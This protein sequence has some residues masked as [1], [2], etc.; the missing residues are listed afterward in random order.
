MSSQSNERY[1]NFD[2]LRLLLAA[3]VAFVHAW[4][5]VDPD[6]HW[7]A[8]VMAV[9]AFL[10]ISGFLVLK[11]I[12]NSS[13]LLEFFGKRALRV[14]PALL[15][16]FALCV[17][18]F[19]APMAYNSLLNWLT[20]GLYTLPFRANGPLWSLLWEEIAYGSLALVWIAG[21][22][23]R[24]AVVWLMLVLAVCV[25]WLGPQHDP[26]LKILLY[27]PAAFLAG[28]LMYLHRASLLKVHWLI[29]TA[30]FYVMLQWRFVPDGRLLGGAALMLVQSFGVVWLGMAGP[31]ILPIRIPDISY[32]L[33]IYHWP[34]LT[35]L[36]G[37]FGIKDLT[38]LLLVGS[39]VL[40][41]LTL[42]SWYLVEAP[43][44]RLK[45]YL[46][47]SRVASTGV[48]TPV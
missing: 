24:P 37:T 42:A 18:L 4:F 36:V 2:L 1:P 40:L 29:P 39:V 47:A 41:P 17:V 45:R 19:D 6:F 3:E 31:R 27:L 34:V 10:A 33:Y 11:S 21:G 48:A 38:T 30:A 8:F 15:A 5:L 32:G 23:R 28:N 9:P 26:H 46:P 20:G 16:S 22:Y 7:D 43:A 14:M 35:F 12:E 13:S 25:A 44:L